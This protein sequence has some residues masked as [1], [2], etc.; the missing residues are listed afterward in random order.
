[1]LGFL[2]R[3]FSPELLDLELLGLF[4][5]F[6]ILPFVLL[7]VFLIDLTRLIFACIKSI[8]KVF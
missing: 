4:E 8:L 6:L 7:E 3:G 2:H 5:S 1:M